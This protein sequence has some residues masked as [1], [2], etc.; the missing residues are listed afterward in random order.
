MIFTIDGKSLVNVLSNATMIQIPDT[1]E[2][3]MQDSFAVCNL[4]NE[5]I[6]P[7]SVTDIHGAF[8]Q[9]LHKITV[10]SGNTKYKSVNGNLY[11]A[12]VKIL[13][14]YVT[15]DKEVVLP[16]TVEI[17]K[18]RCFY[19]QSNIEN[20][21]LSDNLKQL[22]AFA[23]QGIN[24]AELT[25]P[26]TVNSIAPQAFHNV[27][28]NVNIDEKNE[29]YKSVDGIFI[30]SKDGTELCSISKN[31]E[32]YKI[33][34][35]VE[36]IKS[37]S[38]YAKDKFKSIDIGGKIKTI[39]NHAFDYCYILQAVTISSSVQSMDS[40][41]FSR[42]NNL[43]SIKIDNKQNSIKNAPWGAPYGLRAVE[44]AE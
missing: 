35:T 7:K 25:I 23:L 29:K 24:A 22:E 43:T 10:A 28:I 41:V 38:F 15:N 18:T 21:T 4:L 31:L 8:P 11:D 20:L 34:N 36:T 17:L 33:P 44:W 9:N 30:L 37:Y 39:E 40:E 12:D 6:I 14:K 2:V 32:S 19:G 26:A 3:I 16:N 1:V 42:C 13:Y 5:I 27:N